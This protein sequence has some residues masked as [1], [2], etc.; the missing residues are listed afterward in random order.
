M[1]NFHP[2]SNSTA[3]AFTDKQNNTLHLT[4]ESQSAEQSMYLRTSSSIFSFA[5]KTQSS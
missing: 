4:T 1:L 5:P 3:L 2:L